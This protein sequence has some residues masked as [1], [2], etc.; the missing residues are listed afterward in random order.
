MDELTPD[1]LNQYERL[2]PL[3]DN[4]IYPGPSR[5]SSDTSARTPEY[6]GRKGT[7]TTPFWVE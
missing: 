1:E 5:Y 7:I 4:N 2:G 6:S 3:Y